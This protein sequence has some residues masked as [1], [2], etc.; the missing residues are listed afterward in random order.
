MFWAQQARSKSKCFVVVA[1]ARRLFVIFSDSVT[2]FDV[3][4][5]TGLYD[6][7]HADVSSTKH[8]T[9]RLIVHPDYQPGK[10]THN[11]ALIKLS[12]PVVFERRLLPICLPYPSSKR[13]GE[14]F[15]TN[16]YKTGFLDSKYVGQVG[17]T[18]SWPEPNE[19]SENA[20]CRPRK[21]GLPILEETHCGSQS[22]SSGVGC[23]GV[24][25]G[26]ALICK[27]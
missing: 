21:F 17:T 10:G 5:T 14:K 15:F 24:I 7:C 22:H 25:G 2:P 4:V 11:L 13:F 27:V 18:V 6:R 26:P 3:K 1:T 23:A 9:E 19:G 20:F 8:S 16:T 12:A